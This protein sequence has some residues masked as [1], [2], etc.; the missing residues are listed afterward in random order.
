M[1]RYFC[2][3]F[4][5]LL[6]SNQYLVRSSAYRLDV[7]QR[8]KGEQLCGTH[9]THKIDLAEWSFTIKV[10]KTHNALLLI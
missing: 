6:G 3:A 4:A 9:R 5:E 8:A 1:G 7:R 10:F 2:S